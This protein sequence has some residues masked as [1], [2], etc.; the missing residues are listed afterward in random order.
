[1]AD[2][3][4]LDDSCDARNEMVRDQIVA[5]GIRDARV[6]A[7]IRSIPR[8]RFVPASHR[9]LAHDDRALPIGGGQTVSQPFI[10]A[11]MTERLRLEP[12]H[13]V[14]EIG[15][16]SGYQAAVLARLVRHVHTVERLASLAESAGA[17]LADIGVTNVSCHVG[18]GTCGWP[19]DAPYDRII[20]T[21]GAPSIP[22]PLVDQLDVGG[23]LIIPVGD[24]KS[25]TLTLV[26]KRRSG[27]VERPLY[28]CRFV[29]LIGVYGWSE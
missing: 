7:A 15:T 24:A 16:G 19:D 14:L 4:V 23:L 10:V 2:E 27:T 13:T 20:V 8:E 29:K 9:H 11:S 26:E 18:D 12:D 17:L 21:A 3:G 22:S 5:R 6:L 1:M 25:Q 28:A